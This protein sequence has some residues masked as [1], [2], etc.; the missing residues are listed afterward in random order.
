MSDVKVSDLNKDKELNTLIDQIKSFH[1]KNINAIAYMIY[2]N[3]ENSKQQD[4]MSIV[5]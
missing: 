2:D 1:V 3:F 5:D 4:E